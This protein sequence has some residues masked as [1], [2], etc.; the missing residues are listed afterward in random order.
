MYSGDAE[1]LFPFRVAQSLVDLRGDRWKALAERAC[2]A[3]ADSIDQLAFSL[4]LIRLCGC[5]TCHTNSYRALRGCTSCAG[6]TIRRFKGT[7][8]ELEHLYQE[9]IVEVETYL[10]EEQQNDD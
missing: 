6:H 3:P 1:I 7:D 9:T 2:A 5:L 10:Y 8:E 4:L